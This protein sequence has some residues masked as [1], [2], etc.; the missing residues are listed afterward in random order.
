M[1]VKHAALKSKQLTIEDIIN[2]TAIL[3]FCGVVQAHEHFNSKAHQEAIDFFKR[4]LREKVSKA[5]EGTPA[6]K[7]VTITDF[8]GRKKPL[9]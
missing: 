6:R 1:G 5:H 8:F 4:D 2:D 3:N 9:N 7:E